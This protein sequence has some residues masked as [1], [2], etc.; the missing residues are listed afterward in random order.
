MQDRYVG[1]I[2]DYFKYGLLRALSPGRRLGVAWYAFPDEDHNADGKHI[3]YLEDAARWKG[4][5]PALFDELKAIVDAK[6]RSINSIEQSGILGEAAFHS[7][8][9]EC[10]ESSFAVREEWRRRWFNSVLEHLKYSDLVF[11]DPDNGICADNQFRYSAR[12]NW[13]RIPESEVTAL[14]ENRTSIL[15]HHN[16]RFKGGHYLEVQHWM[17]R[18]SGCTYAVRWRAGTGRTFFIIN[19]RDEDLGV[20]QELV[21]RW[22]PK[23]ELNFLDSSRNSVSL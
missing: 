17:R 7:T 18:I 6:R 8:L 10:E 21:S 3:S 4:S 22:G 12:K 5:D 2:G 11:I 16:S 19:P 13:K 20:I 15:Y 9:L 23:A 1:D 14:S